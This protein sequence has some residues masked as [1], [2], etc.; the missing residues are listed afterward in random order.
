MD[1]VHSSIQFFC[2]ILRRAYMWAPAFILDPYD[3]WNRIAKPVFDIKWDL[4]WSTDWAPWILAGLLVWTGILTYHE[5]RMRLPPEDTRPDMTL[6]AAFLYLISDSNWSMSRSYDGGDIVVQ[7]TKAVSDA[8]HSGRLKS[9]G[10]RYSN[11]GNVS[12]ALIP[13]LAWSSPHNLSWFSII[14]DDVVQGR[15]VLSHPT[16]DGGYRDVMVSRRQ[17][18][19]LWPKASL[20]ARLLDKTRKD[21]RGAFPDEILKGKN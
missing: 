16:E 21:R 9:W 4:P 19:Q 3:L 14:L 2:G 13:T 18:E 6:R 12:Q 10:C 20:G 7:A 1:I 17:I 5:L 8:A 11:Y 15:D